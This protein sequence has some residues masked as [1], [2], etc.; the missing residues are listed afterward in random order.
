MSDKP[1]VLIVG[2]GLGG[3]T[4]AILLERA[5]FEYRVFEQSEEFRPYG[6]AIGLGFNVMPLMEQLDLLED[7]RA[8]SKIIEVTS[9]W[10]DS[11]DLIRS[12][13]LK[14]NRTLTGYD[15]LMMSRFD[16][17]QILLSRVPKERIFM[18]HKIESIL[19]DK[20]RVTI[21]CTNNTFHQADI[22]VGADGAYSAVRQSLYD[23]LSMTGKLPEA[24]STLLKIRHT[25]YLGTTQPM[26]PADF[27][28]LDE[29][30]SH[31]DTILGS[32]GPETWR[33][34][35][36][37][38]NRI[39]W[40]IDVQVMDDEMVDP[41]CDTSRNSEYSPDKDFKVPE[42]WRGFKLPIQGT[43]G[44]LIDATP[45]EYRTKATIEEKVFETWYNG[46]TV[47]IGDA[48]HRMLPNFGRSGLNAMLDAVILAN[49]L[50][51]INPPTPF[52]SST[53]PMSPTA[54]A[55]LLPS[56][57][58]SFSSTTTNSSSSRRPS[59]STV[60]TTST[61]NPTT[62]G[63][64]SPTL[65]SNSRGQKLIKAAFETYYKERY[66]IMMSE[67]AASQ[68][69]FRVMAGQSK[70]ESIK[71]SVMQ[72]VMPKWLS[73]K[74][75]FKA[76]YRPQAAFLERLE[77]KGTLPVQEQKL[78]KKYL[79]MQFHLRAERNQRARATS[80]A[81]HSMAI[82]AGEE[83]GVRSSENLSTLKATRTRTR[84]TTTS[85]IDE[86]LPRG[87]IAPGSSLDLFQRSL[88]H[89]ITKD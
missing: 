54:G 80:L 74:S 68:Q 24:D 87:G 42:S 60:T 73:N 27:M 31:C 51:E 55:M 10:K 34:F 82:G 6:S 57:S 50:Y 45:A 4:M 15:S 84:S 75:E 18:N 53:T 58:S 47:L 70:T 9:I 26:N 48:C 62:G 89:M 64:G 38:N 76:S 41:Y 44:D 43:V 71:R 36:I 49:A 67:L 14:D 39:S 46:R 69:M 77:N 17:H 29:P 72:K 78:S 88:A 11:M 8:I 40:R 7:I 65:F 13:R 56:S 28:G 85:S 59:T 81:R 37:P 3:L 83:F 30:I 21:R 66:P 35:T 1:T 12:V 20:H 5:G 63:F 52:S 22:L 32:N 19:Q 86:E 61:N 2:A 23:R 16:L 79:A 25:T 33:Y